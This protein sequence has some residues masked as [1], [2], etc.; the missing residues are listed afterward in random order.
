MRERKPVGWRH[1]GVALAMLGWLA[2]V[3]LPAHATHQR[4][5]L[6]SWAPTS[7]NTVEF[8]ITGAWRRSA[9]S[10]A[11]GGCRD[12]NDA[13]A[14]VLGNIPCSGGD[15]FASVNDVIV[16]YVGGTVFTPGEGSDISSPLS[17][18]LYVVTSID[19]A[20]DWL[21]ATALDPSSLPSIDTTIS[22]T[23]SNSTPRTAFLQDCC[24]V[25]N[26]VGGNQHINNPDGSYRIETLVTPGTGNRPPVSTMPPIVLCPLN[27][28]CTF[29]V[30]GSDPDGDPVTFRLS[31]S[32]E[33][34]GSVSGF[35]QPGPTAA[36]NAA[37]ISSSGLYTWNTTGATVGGVGS[38][39][40]YSTQVSIEDRTPGNVVKSK[41][42]VDFLIQLVV[43]SG[44]APVFDHPPTPQCGSTINVNPGAT[45]TFTAQASDS[46]FGQTV[47]L[48]AVG[49][50]SGATLTP[51]LPTTANPV[52]SVFNWG[53][54]G[55]D[56]GTTHVVTFTATDSANL[57]TQCSVTITVAQCQSNADCNDDSLC[58]S[59]IC[60]P[61]NPGANAGGCL[62]TAVT[63]NACQVC[64]PALGCTGAVCTPVFSPT[65]TPT[66]PPAVC[67]DGVIASPEAC[68]QGVLN[69]TAGSCCSATCTFRSTGTACTD[70]GLACTTDTCGGVS[71]MCQ[72]APGN[73]GTACRSAAGACDVTEIC[74]GSSATCPGDGVQPNTWICRAATDTCD[75][76]ETCN[77]SSASCPSDALQSSSTTCRA[78]AGACDAAE[79]C[80]G[81]SA[82]CPPDALRSNAFTC[83]ASAGVCDTAE[84]CTGSDIACPADTKSSAVCRAMAG[85]CDAAE[86]C[87]GVGDECPADLL[88]PATTTCRGAAG[89]CDVPE[90]CDGI[91]TNCPTD[92]FEPSSTACRPSGGDCDVAETCTGTAAA[93]P[94]DAVKPNTITCRATLGICDLAEHCTGSGAA[95]PADAKSSAVCRA[96]AGVCDLAESCTGSGNDCPADAKSAAVCR[97]AASVCDV[98]ELCDGAADTCPTNRIQPDGMPC[99]DLLYCNGDETCLSGSCT[100]N[101]N[102]C[103]LCDETSNACQNEL[104]PVIRQHGCRTGPKSRLLLKNRT[105]D[106]ADKLIWKLANAA[107]TSFAELSDPVVST[108]YA[109]CLYA[110]P[111]GALILEMGVPAG[112]KWLISGSNKGFKYFDPPAVEDGAQKIRLKSGSS[113]R[114]K[115][116]I[117]GRGVNLGDPLTANR[118]PLPVVA[119]FTNMASGTCW[120]ASYSTPD[121]NTPD[122]FKARQ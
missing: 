89:M 63:C 56:A 44:L 45:V 83:R 24:R 40:Y 108:D 3:P 5:S 11:N 55:F 4:A 46:D 29:Q 42:A 113:N 15:G 109:F 1:V 67:G 53:T 101:P 119:Q 66:I 88:A 110:G 64:Q 41:I 58:T 52:S 102:P 78:S 18:L 8:T 76:P 90:R 12:V 121:K 62:N 21:Y 73:A 99:T 61:T 75:A 7:G 51:L 37:T 17:A 116:L 118:L 111:T 86:S 84:P 98:A 85:A 28:I 97:G 100:D 39:T 33:A 92:A 54:G 36:P 87:D 106:D 71:A 25:S 74:T 105:N 82:A 114:T 38:N 57:Q 9:Y 81:S 103:V 95:C 49:V 31:T 50:P 107:T 43:Q 59:D 69:G 91:G 96:A 80:T 48:N 93:C 20:N 122:S 6:I 19:P 13:I 68:D 60:A 22:K 94:P 120:E 79:Q 34:S 16:E 30:P 14:P 65:P 104:C 2:A 26:T 115:L 117:K 47:T 77:G 72:H 112:P 32:T 70:D 10:T 27:G 35:K 23:Y